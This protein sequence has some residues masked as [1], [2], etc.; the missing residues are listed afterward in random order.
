MTNNIVLA[1]SFED[2]EPLILPSLIRTKS[3][4]EI[5]PRLDVWSYRDNSVSINLKF[6]TIE[7]V[8]PEFIVGMKSVLI[9]Y[10]ENRA[11]ESLINMFYRIRHLCM[12]LTANR[13]EPLL[14][15][16]SID[17][18]NYRGSLDA[19]N[20]WYLSSLAGVL[21]RWHDYGVPG[22]SADAKALLVQ[23]RLKG[24][25]K[26]VAVLTMDPNQG[27]LTG[28]EL[29]AISSALNDAYAAGG[30]ALDH[31]L[32]VW[33]FMLLGQRPVQYAAL[34]ACDIMVGQTKDGSTR[35][36]L[37]VPRAKQQTAMSRLA[38]KDRLLIPQIGEL[39]AQYAVA[40]KLRFDGVLG[41]SG[42]APLFPQKTLDA[43]TAPNGFEYHQTSVA[44]GRTLKEVLGNLDVRS[45]RTG[46]SIHI[47]ARRF[48]HT[49]GTRAAAEGHGALLIA[50]LLDHTDTQNVGVYVQ[51][52]PEMLERIDRAM[53]TV[54]APMAQA[55]AGTLICD[56]S[57]ALRGNDPSSRIVD[58]RFDTSFKPMGN[59]GSY[60]FCSFAAPIACYTCRSFQPWLDGAHERVLDHLISER[61]RL[62]VSA[63]MRIASVNDRTILAVAQVVVLCQEMQKKMTDGDSRG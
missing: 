17:L 24:N 5:D 31:Y 14:T 20:S 12:T 28:I 4:V 37:R 43:P 1:T 50:E 57:E 2:Q 16:T 15:I 54:M 11:G 62:K 53:A 7:G 27:P 29:Q 25:P 6:S 9:W 36:S 26:G 61:E 35:Y 19:S 41:D 44:V 39:L 46:N 63:D 45:E 56:E 21:K 49:V 22:V 18:I 58:P 30:I 55:F 40:I 34:K 3:G 10:A 48:R 60:S 13:A 42:Q 59:C 23:L 33:L 32:L 47:N 52:T 38:F 8:A 51:S